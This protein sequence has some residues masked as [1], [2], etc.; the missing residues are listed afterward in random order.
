[1]QLPTKRPFKAQF[2]NDQEK[3][4]HSMVQRLS[5]L[6]K[7]YKKD[8]DAKFAE[9]KEAWKKREAKVQEKR[10]AYTKEAK[11]KKYQKE[12]RAKSKPGK[13]D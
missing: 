12:Q 1:M 3:K 4:I 7:E 6:D 9:K 2:M 11:K 13:F 5:M 10:D 8:K